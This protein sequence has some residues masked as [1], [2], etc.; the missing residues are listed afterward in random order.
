MTKFIDELKISKTL[1][2]IFILIVILG[3]FAHIMFISQP[4]FID[5][6]HIIRNQL[7]FI[8]ERTIVP[9]HA[10]YP[11]FFYYISLPATA[12]SILW[13]YIFYDYDSI[14]QVASQMYLFERRELALGARLFNVFAVYAA[15]MI[16]A[17]IIWYKV[18]PISAI[19]SFLIIMSTPNILRYSAYAMPDATLMLFGALTLW[20]LY[21]VQSIYDYRKFFLAASVVGLA[22]S[23]KYNAAVLIFPVAIWGVLVFYCAGELF[24][25]RFFLYALISACIALISFFIGSPGWII[26]TDF[27][28]SEL[29][30]EMEH[31]ARGHL[32]NT[33]IVFIGQIELLF[34]N[35]PAIFIF[36]LFGLFFAFRNNLNS[37]VLPASVLFGA[38]SL[39]AS[40]EKQSFHYLFPAIPGIVILASYTIDTIVRY[41]GRT[42]TIAIT[43]IALC[44]S[45]F[46]AF[47][48]IN[49]MK[50]N[51]T[52]I[53]KSWIVNNIP[54]QSYILVPRSYIPKLYTETDLDEL[55]KSDLYTILKT[56]PLSSEP[57]FKIKYYEY[58][59]NYNFDLIEESE[60]KY[61]VT[62]SSTFRR[63]FKFGLFTSIKPSQSDPI[64]DIFRRRQDFYVRL[65]ESPDWNVVFEADTG[66]GPRTLVFRRSSERK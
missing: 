32:G 6:Q 46:S 43:F 48:S 44:A 10:R 20:L 27:F 45:L 54:E 13:K 19:L 4:F 61:I 63:Y 24:S 9:D 64:Y 7:K 52:D 25:K 60:A 11:T 38:L 15:G 12:G 41:L 49:F 2:F 26:K 30:F 16:T 59:F 58:D 42:G 55:R 37:A 31:A 8:H 34:K 51:T 35:I 36:S 28:M 14:K 23:T 33:G 3:A 47:Y 65:F 56:D 50:P 53:T 1:I 22:I 17:S 39:A 40:S 29:N 21:K 5:E 18:S 62:S 66:N 57:I